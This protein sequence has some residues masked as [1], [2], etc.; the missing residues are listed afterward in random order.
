MGLWG[1]EVRSVKLQEL[2]VWGPLCGP[3]GPMWD[4]GAPGPEM[5]VLCVFGAHQRMGDSTPA[6]RV[7]EESLD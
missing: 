6:P 7:A 2:Q 5:G 4:A 1:W 3:W